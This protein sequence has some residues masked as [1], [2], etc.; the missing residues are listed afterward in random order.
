M[1]NSTF[2]EN[3]GVCE[4]SPKR[5]REP[6]GDVSGPRSITQK[7]G[8]EGPSNIYYLCYL[9][10]PI[11]TYYWLLLP[12]AMYWSSWWKIIIHTKT[13]H[14]L[15]ATT[16]LHNCPQEHIAERLQRW[17]IELAKKRNTLRQKQYFENS[18][19]YLRRLGRAS[20]SKNHNEHF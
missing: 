17:D 9:L 8:C 5:C 1:V 14:H 12:W 3:T 13:N 2:A 19:K 18:Q 7:A 15:W 4:R 11:I 20:I 10:L 6:P 16:T